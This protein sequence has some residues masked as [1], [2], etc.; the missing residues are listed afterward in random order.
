MSFESDFFPDRFSQFLERGLMPEDHGF[1]RIQVLPH[2]ANSLRV[3]DEL[4]ASQKKGTSPICFAPS[5]QVFFGSSES[6]ALRW[7][8]IVIA[9][10]ARQIARLAYLH[11]ARLVSQLPRAKAH[12][13]PISFRSLSLARRVFRAGGSRQFVAL[14]LQA[15][16]RATP[17]MSPR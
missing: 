14:L 1:N 3:R 4:S 15:E 17:T 16:P 6:R 2:C 11:L 13:V 7:A 5:G 10:S 8:T 12:G 9:L